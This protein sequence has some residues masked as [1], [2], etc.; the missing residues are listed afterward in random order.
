MIKMIAFDLDGTICDT[1]PMC[2]EAFRQAVYPY[3]KR[4]LTKE[5]IVQTFGLNEVGMIKALLPEDWE[6]ALNDFYCIYENIH[7]MCNTPF[8][9]IRSLIE[10]L[11][12]KSM[13]VALITGKGERSYCITLKK[14]NMENVF[15]E[16]MAG[17]ENHNNKTESIS[18]LLHKYTIKENEFY[19]VGDAISDVIACAQAEVVCL[20]AAWADCTNPE[21]LRKVNPSHVFEKVSDLK[22]FL[23]RHFI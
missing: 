7:G 4:Q 8:P 14:L 17:S 19:Y 16:I 15:D 12:A 23:K 5:E 20:S 6:T 1:I 13:P 3:A 2:I 11:K 18:Q 9:G 22:N 21:Q 10:S